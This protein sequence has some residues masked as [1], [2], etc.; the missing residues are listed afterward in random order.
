MSS[1][2]CWQQKEDIFCFDFFFYFLSFFAFFLLSID[3]SVA[4]EWAGHQFTVWT[5]C[6]SMYSSQSQNF[7]LFTGTVPYIPG[8]IYRYTGTVPVF[9]YLSLFFYWPS[10][11]LLKW[12]QEGSWE[13]RN[14]GTL[15]WGERDTRV[16]GGR[17]LCRVLVGEHCLRRKTSPRQMFVGAQSAMTPPSTIWKPQRFLSRTMIHK[18]T[19][20]TSS[21]SSGMSTKRCKYLTHTQ[22]DG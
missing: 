15:A 4:E 17:C 6:S 20:N 22:T 7:W 10:C 12:H 9:V 19:R 1:S 18:R 11:S 2:C 16:K 8:P 13:G 5:R 14:L 3:F 21:R